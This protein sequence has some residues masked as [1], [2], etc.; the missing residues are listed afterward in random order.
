MKELADKKVTIEGALRRAS[1]RFTES[2]IEQPRD[3]AEILLA[4]LMGW[5]RLELFLERFSPL[6]KDLAPAFE[7]V[8][9]RRAG[10]EPAAY[11]IGSKEFY[12]LEFA[13]NREVLIPRP[14]TE[15]LVDAILEWV[16][17]RA[18]DICGIDL[19]SGS[20]NLVITLAYHLPHALFYA[21]DLSTGALRLAAAN[22]A[23]HGVSAQI[24]FCQGDY[25]AAL[26][27]VEP[28]P[29]FN[30]VTANPPYLSTAEMEALP[31]AI[32]YYEPRLALDG[33]P[34]GLNAY[35]TILSA[36]PG[37]VQG[38]GLMVLEI[39]SAQGADILSLCRHSTL[40]HKLT[41]LRDYRDYPRVLLGS[42]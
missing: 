10:G 2:G 7:K 23:R 17:G 20:G 24:R 15:L 39:G 37:Y 12:G 5:N 34:D 38:P 22:A 8:V 31:P 25:F 13:V 6:G 28:P 36:M 11:I 14:E 32:R 41:L 29:R 1:S 21:V 4:N 27:Q 35:R 19:G 9:E 40:F 26:S 30:L 3:E 18:G 42:F 16:R 33:G